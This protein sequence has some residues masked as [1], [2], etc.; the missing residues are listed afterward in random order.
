MPLVFNSAIAF[1]LTACLAFAC[2][3]MLRALSEESAVASIE[4]LVP[5]LMLMSVFAVI[6]IFDALSIAMPPL[7]STIELLLLS[8]I[9]ISPLLSFSV[10]LCP[11]GV[12]ISMITSFSSNVTSILER[13]T[14]AFLSLFLFGG[15]AGARLVLYTLP[16]MIGL[17]G[18]SFMKPR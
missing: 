13:V 17:R 9:A 7:P 6:V 15:Y 18:S 1:A 16:R 5:A 10:M 11:P 8:L 12:L 2:S 14:I 4:R 3:V